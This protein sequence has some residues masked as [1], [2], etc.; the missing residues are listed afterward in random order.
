MVVLS[1]MSIA[2]YP[3][4][5]QSVKISTAEKIR[6]DAREILNAADVFYSMNCQNAVVTTPTVANLQALNLLKSTRTIINP[7]GTNYTITF[8]NVKSLRTQIMVSATFNDAGL[9]G[10]V[11]ARS[12]ESRLVGTTV[13]WLKTPMIIE[14]YA[15][16]Q[17]LEDQGLF[18]AKPCVNI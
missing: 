18:G 8:N 3:Y 2:A 7:W 9:A 5:L 4:I 12:R 15:L 6:D 13:Q 10:F 17:S 16:I 14:D 11:Y 1:V